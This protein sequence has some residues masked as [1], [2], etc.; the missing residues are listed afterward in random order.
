MKINGSR[1]LVQV[2]GF[3]AG[4][5]SFKYC[6]RFV[7]GTLRILSKMLT[8]GMCGACLIGLTSSWEIIWGGQGNWGE[9]KIG[10]GDVEVDYNKNKLRLVLGKSGPIYWVGCKEGITYTTP[11]ERRGIWKSWEKCISLYLGKR[12]MRFKK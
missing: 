2:S 7:G 11:E 10:E 12:D 1:F 6:P 9:K 3:H 5:V 8:K 4:C